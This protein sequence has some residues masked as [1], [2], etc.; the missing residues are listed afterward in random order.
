[1]A[2]LRADDDLE[3]PETSPYLRRSKRVEVRR[4]A[5]RWR[6]LLLLGSLIVMLMAAVLAVAAFRISTY[7]VTSPRFTL[8]ESFTVRGGEHTGSEW[9]GQVFAADLG[10]S[11]FEVPL[12]QRR[13]QLMAYPWVESAYVVRGWPNRLQVLIN[14]RKPVAFVRLPQGL[15]LIDREGMLLPLP[16]GRKF[17]FPVVTGLTEKQPPAD[18]KGRVGLMLAVLEDLDREKPPRSEEVSEIDLSDPK[19]AAVTVSA[20]GSAVLV[21]LGNAH[22]LARYK[23]FLENIENWREQYG[24]VRSVDLRY[25]KQV[26]VKP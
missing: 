14:E 6:R 5:V 15:S 1:M 18:R 24:S 3:S 26:I 21:H 11:V 16:R 22:F 25:E 20:A 8:R 2:V 10:R 7:L 12:D 19:D 23:L 4:S 17:R 9:I 13:D